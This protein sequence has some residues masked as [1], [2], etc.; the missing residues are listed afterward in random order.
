LSPRRSS[1][2]RSPHSGLRAASFSHVGGDIVLEILPPTVYVERAAGGQFLNFDLRFTNGG[3]KPYRVTSIELTG[4]D[5]G[6]ALVLRRGVDEH[7]LRPGIETVPDR[8]VPPGRSL[9]VFNPLHTISSSPDLSAVRIRC[10]LAADEGEALVE[11]E[12]SPVAYEQRTELVLPLAGR[13]LVAAGHDFLSPHRRIDP[14]HPVAAEFGL[15]ANSGR[16]A[17]DFSLVG[18]TG[19]LFTQDRARLDDWFGFGASV[20]S[21][22]SGPVVAA[23]GDVADNRFTAT[24][25]SSPRSRRIRPARSSET[26]S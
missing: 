8:L 15:R 2:R 19:E 24:E 17:D 25:S 14:S 20:R 13:V 21:P 26:T 9:L 10:A 22:G 1:P 5:V 16:Y 3:S 12:V 23:L 7:G 6:G 18:E 4:F 11:A